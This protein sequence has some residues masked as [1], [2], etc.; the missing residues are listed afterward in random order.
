M[1]AISAFCFFVETYA[2]QRREISFGDRLHLGFRAADARL[3]KTSPSTGGENVP[4]RILPLLDGCLFERA[5][6]DK[7]WIVEALA[8]LRIRLPFLKEKVV[9]AVTA[10]CVRMVV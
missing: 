5:T 8:S 9:V 7:P 10:F 1:E 6:E 2:V 4:Y 3:E